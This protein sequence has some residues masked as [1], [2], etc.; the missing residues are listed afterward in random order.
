MVDDTEVFFKE[1]E[2][3]CEAADGDFSVENISGYRY[4]WCKFYDSEPLNIG[5]A[6]LFPRGYEGDRESIYI[7]SPKAGEFNFNIPRGASGRIEI[8]SSVFD[9]GY[10]DYLAIH[11]SGGRVQGKLSVNE[12]IARRRDSEFVLE[13]L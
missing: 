5:V 2:L 3:F 11:S 7:H 13:L 4:A 1:L 8:R 9:D 6:G 12:V 10:V